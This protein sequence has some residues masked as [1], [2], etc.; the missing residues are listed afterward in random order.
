MAESKTRTRSPPCAV[1]GSSLA[2][3][4]NDGRGRVR[5]VRRVRR[6]RERERETRRAFS[7]SRW[8]ESRAAAGFNK[9]GSAQ[10]PRRMAHGRPRFRT[11]AT[12]APLPRRH[13][14][15]S[16]AFSFTARVASLMGVKS[17]RLC[18]LRH[19]SAGPL[20]Q[21]VFSLSVVRFFFTLHR[22]EC[23]RC[24]SASSAGRKH[25]A[26]YCRPYR[27]ELSLSAKLFE[28]R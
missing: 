28:V 13:H 1:R 20:I 8:S 23:R 16:A 27:V 19:D 5:R 21:R 6:A 25:L 14:F 26:F 15:F 17:F 24:R 22:D 11:M 7:A 18:V 10:P 2:L 9:R 12:S 4:K 3:F